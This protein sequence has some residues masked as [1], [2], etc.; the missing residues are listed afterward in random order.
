MPRTT[1]DYT[2]NLS[3]EV[4]AS[5]LSNLITSVAILPSAF[6]DSRLHLLAVSKRWNRLIMDSSIFWDTIVILPCSSELTL[7]LAKIADEWQRIRWNDGQILS[8]F[9]LQSDQ[10]A[11]INRPG[12][13]DSSE[14]FRIVEDGILTMDGSTTSF[15]ATL[16][17]KDG[18]DAFFSIPPGSFDFLETLLICVPSLPTQ[19][20]AQATAEMLTEGLPHFDAFHSLPRLHSAVISIANG[21]DPL[22]FKIPWYQLVNIDMINT[23][24]VPDMF[25]EVLFS[26]GPSLEDGSFT[27]RFE[28]IRRSS[29][30]SPNNTFDIVKP[31]FV[32]HLRLRLIDPTLDTRIF[33]RIH[34][35]ALCTLR[36]ELVQD[37]L[38]EGWAMSIYKALLS[39]SRNTLKSLG[40]SDT[41][42][43]GYMDEEAEHPTL[44]YTPSN[45]QQ[46]LDE[47]LASLPNLKHLHLPIGVYIPQNTA[48][49]IAQGILLPSLTSLDASSTV[50]VDILGMVER[51]NELAYHFT[52]SIG[53]SGLDDALAG[54]GVSPPFLSDLL[55]VTPPDNF[56]AVEAMKHRLLSS[57]SSQ[58]TALDIRYANLQVL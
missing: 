56:S 33:S 32:Q 52:D 26:T 38:K 31:L 14:R 46:D 20:L 25:M 35:T 55:L 50:G 39:K 6:G 53:F 17:T 40:F 2:E 48:D 43:R 44:F 34:L 27:I 24:I 21:I 29:P 3:D 5:I 30:S 13:W 9:L 23:T 10:L 8:S 41:P 22:A 54:I 36:I 16:S 28:E 57:S 47:L 37:R 4:L 42:F 11:E 51:R 15:Y 49:K 19:S 7:R 18:I 45:R 1:T 12:P 58:G